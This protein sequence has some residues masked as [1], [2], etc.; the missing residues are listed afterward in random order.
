MKT[1]KVLI[2]G[3]S[4]GLGS[5]IVK[6]FQKEDYRL[7]LHSHGKKPGFFDADLSKE[8]EVEKLLEKIGYDIDIFIHSVSTP[9]ENKL[10][11]EKSWADFESHL[12]LQLKAF[13]LIAKKIIPH[14]KSQKWGR[15]IA[16][17]TEYTAGVPPTHISDYVTAK[18]AMLGLS[19]C[20]AA[21]YG[22]F[23]ITCN[24]VSPGTMETN[25]T[26]GLPKKLKEII[27][28]EYPSGKLVDPN[29]VAGKV[30]FLC[31]EEAKTINGE[32]IVI[33]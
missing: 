26:A 13:F 2:T 15:I 10:I 30:A 12:D 23:R 22:K 4:G 27:A 5:A 3:A 24:V 17:A 16:I 20:I 14:M 18:Y 25:L 9:I 33:T 19:K 21:E 32:N 29:I 7:F 8:D 6:R 31:S 11:E 1:K 28:S